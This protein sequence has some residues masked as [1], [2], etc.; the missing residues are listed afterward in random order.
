MTPFDDKCQN[1]QTPFFTFFIFDKSMLMKVTDRLADRQKDRQT[2]KWTDRLTDRQT[3]TDKPMSVDEIL[4]ICAEMC[5]IILMLNFILHRCDIIVKSKIFKVSSWN[6]WSR[7]LMILLKIAI[8]AYFVNWKPLY[9]F[10]LDG[11]GNECYILSSFLKY[12]QSENA[13]LCR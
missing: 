6:W 5:K 1:L 12:S 10:L 8:R 13:R 11:I 3:G 7:T 4:Q 9:D 2:D